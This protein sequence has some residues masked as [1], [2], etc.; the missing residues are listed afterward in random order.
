[1][2]SITLTMWESC[3]IL[4]GLAVA[5]RIIAYMALHFISTPNKPKL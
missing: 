1:M 5:V 3:A 2:L 4:A